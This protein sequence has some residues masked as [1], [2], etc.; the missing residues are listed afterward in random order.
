MNE[1]RPAAKLYL[2][3]VA[4]AALGAALAAVSHAAVP[5]PARLALAL[6][7]AAATALAA[8][9]PLH[10]GPGTK[11][12]LD[13][14]LLVA[15]VLLF[16]P[17]V[18]VLVVGVGALLA[19]A[20]RR[21]PWDQTL[22]NLALRVLLVAA[23]GGALAAAGWR[24]EHL[25]LDRPGAVLLVAA[26]GLALDL[27]SVLAVATIVAL[28]AGEGVPRTWARAL[29]EIDRPQALGRLAQVGLGVL[30]AGIA[31]VHSWMVALLLLP[32]GALYQ[33]LNHHV[34]LRREA[35]ARLVYQAYHDPLTGLPNR[36][37]LLDR[38]G[39]AL[40]RAGRR[41]EPVALLFLDLDRFKRVNDGLGHA[42]GDRLLVA[43]GERLRACARAGDTVARLGGDEFTLL[44]EGLTDAAEAE[45]VAAAVAA[46]LEAPV[47]LDGQPV[48]VTASI[49]VALA[50]PGGAEPAGLLRDADVAM[51]RAKARG[52]ARVEVFDAAMAAGARERVAFEADLR[53]AV[54]RGELRLAYQPIVELATG[55]VVGAEALARWA[56]PARGVVLPDAFVPLAEETGLI[57]PLGRWVLA[58]AC[59]QGRA[60]QDRF[61]TPPTVSVNLSPRQFQQ[62]GLVEE[63]A[64]AL[65]S[66]GLAPDRLQLE[67]TEGAV[68]ADADG[69]VATLRQ[70]R[71]LG[72][73]LAIDDFGT[74]YSSL[75]YLQRFPID[76]LKVDRR[77]VAGLGR[78]A[79]DTAIVEA[80][81]G[82]AHAL[83]LRVVAEGVETVEQAG[84][85]RELGCELGQGYHFGRPAAAEA[86]AALMAKV[87]FAV[88]HRAHG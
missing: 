40:A 59:R 11:L 71:G 81:V 5:G 69:A 38:L 46:A 50:G 34:R 14:A 9:F 58:E 83:R 4:V 36:A 27:L 55:R 70:L 79:G 39:Q 74:G 67:I 37:L 54:E 18:A 44:L 6:A 87:T 49:G 28:Q 84:R 77:F 23:G 48:A 51:Y 52:K 31:E 66:T 62:P 1:L 60:W 42:A 35:E 80:V 61:P 45:A 21:Q 56:H 25:G 86:M 88:G 2:G 78:D 72:V 76:L 65:R 47:V 85:L 3:A 75:G 30:A 19:D 32:A 10:L 33:A 68:M 63:V 17:G 57:V 24:V 53:Q 16:E 64:A 15:A 20:A 82:L 29:R 73:R 12:S 41:G 26:V 13:T 43:V 7:L 22:F 8:C